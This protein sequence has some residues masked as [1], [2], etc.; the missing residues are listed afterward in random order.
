MVLFGE[1]VLVAVLSNYQ[2][3]WLGD[4]VFKKCLSQIYQ[5]YTIHLHG[6]YPLCIYALLSNKRL[7][8]H[9][10]FSAVFKDHSDNCV[11]VQKLVDF[12]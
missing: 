5:L 7:S 6:Y 3:T 10:K 11:L 1:D 12:E 8:T 4:A 9:R 2:D